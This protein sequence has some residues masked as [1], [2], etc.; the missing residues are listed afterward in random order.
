MLFDQGTPDTS[1]YMIAGYSIFFVVT[2]IYLASLFIRQRNLRRDLET[3]QSLESEAK[4]P[5]PEVQAA[6]AP[7]KPKPTP[8]KSKTPTAKSSRKKTARKR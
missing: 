5:A 2:L 3:L 1:I 8:A 4:E 6:P 7:R